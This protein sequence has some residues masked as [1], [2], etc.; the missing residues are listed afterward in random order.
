M[1]NQ[2]IIILSLLFIYYHISGLATTNILRLT[3][4][5]TIP[6]LSSKCYCDNCGT[7][8]PPLLQLPIVSYIIC[9]GKC[10]SCGSR[11]PLFPLI[12]EII[13]FSGMSIISVLTR[14][15]YIGISASFFFYEIVRITTILL[16][17]KRSTQFVKQ[18]LFAVVSMIPFYFSALFVAS[19]YKI[20]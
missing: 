15:T 20:V 13:I 4:N 17:G 11:I 18:Y 3:S 7:T 8:I 10:K 9:R 12:L 5:N 6:I 19:L 1:T 2:S 14:Y 16:N